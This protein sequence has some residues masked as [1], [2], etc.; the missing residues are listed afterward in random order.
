M[1]AASIRDAA[2]AWATIR[3]EV[4]G[5]YGLNTLRPEDKFELLK[6]II[7]TRGEKALS[8]IFAFSSTLEQYNL[9]T[10]NFNSVR[11]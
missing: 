7:Q 5:H 6:G 10:M 11:H 8:E 2:D 1:A 3:H 9:E 4:L